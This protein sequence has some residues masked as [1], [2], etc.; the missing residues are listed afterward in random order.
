MTSESSSS[1]SDSSSACP[2]M[3]ARPPCESSDFRRSQTS[4]ALRRVVYYIFF[5]G[6]YF[7]YVTIKTVCLSILFICPER[8][9][10]FFSDV[11]HCV[12][13]LR[14]ECSTVD[15]LCERGCGR[16]SFTFTCC[17]VSL[18]NLRS[19]PLSVRLKTTLSYRSFIKFIK[20]SAS[21][22]SPCAS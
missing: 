10:F 4:D 9:C 2:S 22:L 17:I 18:L 15:Y 8:N 7:C 1:S 3:E 13:P 12:E 16:S 20:L 5:R 6:I 19:V 11:I 14:G 21:S